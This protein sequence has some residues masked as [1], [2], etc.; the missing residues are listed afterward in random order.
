MHRAVAINNLQVPQQTYALLTLSLNKH[1]QCRSLKQIKEQIADEIG[2]ISIP[3][4]DKLQH[5]KQLGVLQQQKIAAAAYDQSRSSRLLQPASHD[6][7]QQ[8]SSFASM[9][10]RESIYEHI[11]AINKP[12][13]ISRME[14]PQFRTETVSDS[15]KS[16]RQSEAKYVDLDPF[17]HDYY[18]L[19]TIMDHMVMLEICVLTEE[20]SWRFSIK[21]N[22][23]E[24]VELVYVHAKNAGAD[25]KVRHEDFNI[26]NGEDWTGHLAV[27]GQQWIQI[28]LPS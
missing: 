4:P 23:Y 2:V 11:F 18:F 3:G 5:E 1:S 25:V 15:A 19:A 14:D 16:R 8:R 20:T 26:G 12:I 28:R 9:E 22:S 13:V 24:M 17:V 6:S 21:R 27:S 10:P 7:S